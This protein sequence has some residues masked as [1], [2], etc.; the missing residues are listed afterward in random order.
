MNEWMF[1]SLL[2]YFVVVHKKIDAIVDDFSK[3]PVRSRNDDIFRCSRYFPSVVW[4]A[5]LLFNGSNMQFIY[6]LQVVI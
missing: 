6:D 3:T 1:L 5:D 4:M 2:R